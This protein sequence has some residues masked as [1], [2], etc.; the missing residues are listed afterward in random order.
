MRVTF[1]TTQL[2]FVTGGGSSYDRDAKAREFQKYGCEVTFVTLFSFN[3]KIN[4]ELPYPVREEQLN[5][6]SLSY[7]SFHGAIRDF[8]KKYESQT[9]VYYIDG[10]VFLFGAGRYRKGGGKP[11]VAHFENYGFPTGRMSVSILRRIKFALFWYLEKFFASHWENSVDYFLAVSD[12][13]RD[14]F[15]ARGLRRDKFI[16]M[17]S[18]IDFSF[19]EATGMYS[20]KNNKKFHLLYAGRFIREKGADLLLRAMA[21]LRDLDIGL[22]MVGTG[23]LKEEFVALSE[24][25]NLSNRVFWHDWIPRSE[26]APVFRHADLFVMPSVWAEPSGSASFD[27]MTCGTPVLTSSGTGVV[28]SVGDAGLVFQQGDYHDLA[29]KIRQLYFDQGLREQMSKRGLVRA[30]YSDYRTVS[31][32]VYKLMVS[33]CPQARI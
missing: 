19:A 10:H 30:P 12:T 17:P 2:D 26:M 28:W 8:L 31:S 4:R 13:V 21:E 14:I 9:D 24:K 6:R 3:N 33:L 7:F 16:I 29:L 11:I 32:A 25:L 27:A 22:D 5:Y 23:P 15:V 1:L 18:S 20:C